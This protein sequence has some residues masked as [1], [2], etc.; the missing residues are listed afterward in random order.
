MAIN[1]PESLKTDT[2]HP[3][4]WQTV[5]KSPS[6]QG[7][8]QDA[9]CQHDQLPDEDEQDTIIHDADVLHD[10][11]N[12]TAIDTIADGTL[13]QPE[14]PITELFPIDDVTIPS[15]R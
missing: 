5:P 4:Q 2:G 13:I 1:I 9:N 6:Q 12:C 8:D 14:E 11:D 7:I 3:L 15:E 10:D